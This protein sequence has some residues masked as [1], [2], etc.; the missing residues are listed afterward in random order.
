M[1]INFSNFRDRLNVHVNEMLAD[2]A[3][4]YE[5]KVNKDELYNLYLDSFPSGMNPIFRKRR[6]YDCG[7]CR[8]YLKK[9]GAV[10]IIKDNKLV[11]IWDFDTGSPEKYQPVADALSAYVK[12]KP[13]DS[14]WLH[15]MSTV[16]TLRTYESFE[17]VNAWDHFCTS[18]PRKFVVHG[19]DIDGKKAE[20]RERR[21]VLKRSFSEIS[22]DAV[23]TVLELI[24]QNSLYRGS[25]NKPKLADFKALEDVYN[26]LPDA[27]KDNYLWSVIVTNKGYTASTVKNSSIG[28]L[29]LEISQGVDL[30]EAVTHYERMVAPENY[31]RPK[32]IFTKRML[33]DAQKTVTELGYMDSLGRRFANIDDIT[34][35][36]ILFA[37]RNVSNRLAKKKS[38]NPFE[39]LQKSTAINPKSFS[40]V[41]SISIDKFIS[42][43]LPSAAG[44]DLFFGN[45][46]RN[47]MVSLIAPT[48]AEAPSM[49]KWNNGFSWAYAGNLADSSIKENVKNAGGKVDGV[50][51]F[52][53]QWNDGEKWDRS[54]LDAH[55]IEPN[56]NEI[57]FGWKNDRYTGGQ[58]DVDIIN[59]YQNNPAVENITW[60]NILKMQDG[61]YRFFVN[62]YSRRSGCSGFKAEIQ[63]EDQVYNYVYNRPM[64]T[65]QD[66]EVAVVTLK[67]GKFSI[68]HALDASGETMSQ[69]IWGVNTNQFV[70]V[71]AI[72]YSPNYWDDQNGIGNK[73]VFFMM[74]GCTNP[75]TPNGFFNEYLKNDLL[76]HKRVFEALGAQMRVE[77]TDNQLSGVGVSTTM[78]KTLIVKIKGNVER[79]LKVEF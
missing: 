51:R 35:N 67:N 39:A 8:H 77:P 7:C 33:E 58:L 42:D 70:P 55:C 54:D 29:L 73:H 21:N 75:D 17:S 52:S 74:N 40:R 20:V 61:N 9:F 11:S 59:P 37:D 65:G 16:G 30:D 34:I 13:I 15:T 53:I 76:K 25:E 1:T 19:R 31:K 48:N 14:I 71:S 78:H 44:I 38:T 68:K 3:T 43:V 27:D 69:N 41:E 72:M 5:T 45:D 4:L 56:G 47:N 6:E 50:L 49:F 60:P 36:N 63:F 57:Y 46:L 2:G 79:I 26:A 62:C 64:S 12:S 10:V 22:M 18:V 32:A 66:V 23:D 28:T 24:S